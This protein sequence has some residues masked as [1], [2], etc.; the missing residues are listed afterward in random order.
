MKKQDWKNVQGKI[1]TSSPFRTSKL[2]ILCL[3]AVIGIILMYLSIILSILDFLDYDIKFWLLW[4]VGLVC[5]IFGSVWYIILNVR[6]YSAK[7]LFAMHYSSVFIIEAGSW[8]GT[9]TLIDNGRD[10]WLITNAHCI[11]D[12]ED[13]P[14]S[15]ITCKRLCHGNGV[16]T[17]EHDVKLLAFDEKEDIAILEFVEP[18]GY[19]DIFVSP[20]RVR[21]VQK[22]KNGDKV[23]GLGNLAGEGLAIREGLVS[24]RLVDIEEREYPCIQIENAQGKGM[25]GGAIIDRR[26]R[27]IGIISLVAKD[28]RGYA[29]PID[30]ILEFIQKRCAN[31]CRY[32]KSWKKNSM[33]I[34]YTKRLK[35]ARLIRIKLNKKQMKLDEKFEKFEQKK[36]RCDD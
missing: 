30:K 1:S 4:G 35:R 25:S 18:R 19:M 14:A 33:E 3:V 28:G 36:T 29:I 13:K 17:T 31:S 7:E 8:A 5:V 22:I 27:I 26:G 11:L 23:F 10:W 24:N 16:V 2:I 32:R 20:L 6:P 9:A 15:K 21:S 12:E 34:F